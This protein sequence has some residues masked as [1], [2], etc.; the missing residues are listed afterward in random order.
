MKSKRQNKK[1]GKTRPQ[2]NNSEINSIIE[3]LTGELKNEN[4]QKIQPK[5]NLIEKTKTKAKLKSSLNAVF[6]DLSTT[7][8]KDQI[9]LVGEKFLPGYKIDLKVKNNDVY[10]M[11]WNGR[12][13]NRMHTYAYLYNKSKK[14]NSTIYLPSHWEGSTLFN[15]DYKII[16]DDEYRTLINQT[17]QPYDSFDGRMKATEEFNSRNEINLQ[18]AN[19]D[20]PS[21]VYKK[22]DNPTV[23]DSLAA[24]N[25]CV[26]DDMKLKDI[27]DLF[28]FNDYIKNLDLYKKLEDRQG[29]YDIAHL[30]RDDVSD[31]KNTSN[32]GYSVV[33]KKSY[34]KAFKKFDYDPSKIEWVSDDWYN[35]D[36]VGTCLSKGYVEARGD[37]SYPVGSQVLKDIV[38][39]WLP[40]FLRIY[41]ARSIFRAN[42]S[43]SFWAATLARGRNEPPKIFAP[44]LE[45]RILTHSESNIGKQLNCDFVEGN[46]PHWMCLKKDLHCNH[47]IFSDEDESI[48]EQ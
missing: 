29:T 18:Y 34:I 22:Y 48:L 11:H 36:G 45:D 20:E 35:L 43:F 9:H 25:K 1:A 37:W 47:I 32:G 2:R 24:Y 23:I 3:S 39:D 40:D 27:L 5:P 4:K 46:Y 44:V 8:I 33:S 31:T 16:P 13:G 21:Q 6:K 26:F 42:S 38:F 41:F 30:R 12:F 14:F 15:L 10:L 19:P 17:I 7:D 28:S